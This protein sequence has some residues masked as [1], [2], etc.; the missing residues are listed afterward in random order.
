MARAVVRAALAPGEPV[1]G[2][3]DLVQVA[4]DGVEVD[5]GGWGVAH[6]TDATLRGGREP[7]RGA[8]GV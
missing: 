8:G 2:P 6:R 5:L 3:L 4:L 7:V 1:E